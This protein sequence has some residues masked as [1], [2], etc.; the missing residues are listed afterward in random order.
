MKKNKFSKALKHLKSKKLD[1]KIKKLDEAA[2]TN[3]MSG[4]YQQSPRS[5]VGFRLGPPDPA[6]TFVAAADGSWPPGIPGTAGEPYYVRPPD[7]WSGTVDWETITTPEF[8]FDSA[9]GN[10]TDGLID[11]VTNVVK[12]QLPPG[13][14]GF[15]LGPL[16][17]GFVPNHVNDAFTRIG[18]IEKDTRQFVLLGIIQG[19]WISGLNERV[20]S[21]GGGAYPVWDGSSGKFTASNPSFT[22]DMA[23]WFRNEMLKNRFVKNVSYN[24]VGGIPQTGNP[25]PN[26]PQP[27]GGNGVGGG[28]GAAGSNPDG[29]GTGHGSGGNPDVGTPQGD[30]DPG[31]DPGENDLWGMSGRRKRKNRRGSGAR[32]NRGRKKPDPTPSPTPDPQGGRGGGTGNPTNRRGSGARGNRGRGSEPTPSPK[33]DGPYTPRPQGG[34]GGGQGNPTNPRGSGAKPRPE[35]TPSPKPTGP[36]TP[37]PQGG[38][39]G[40]QGNPTNPRG[41]GATPRPTPTPTPRP[42][43]RPTPTPKPTPKSNTQKAYERNRYNNRPEVKAGLTVK[44]AITKLGNF[45][46]DP[47]GA[48]ADFFGDN[49]TPPAAEYATNIAKSVLFNKPITV[50]QEDIPEKDIDKLIDGFNDNAVWIPISVSTDG[51][52]TPYADDNFYFDDKGNVKSNIGPN[53]EKAYYKKNNTGPVDADVG[54]AGYDNPLAAAGQAQVQ[55]VT[56]GDGKPYI[57]YTDH[58]YHNLTS[59]DPGE[60]PDP[61]KTAL[62][63]ALHALTGKADPTKPNTGGMSGYPSNVKGDVKTEVKIDLDDPRVSDAFRE[64]VKREIKYN[65]SGVNTKNESFKSKGRF[66]KEDKKRILR[67]IKQPLR[68]IKQLPKTEKLKGY[69]PNFKGKY[70]PQNTPDVTASK[71]SDQ[72]VMAKNAEGQAWSVGDKYLKGWETTGRMNHVYAR[73]GESDKFFEQ[74][75]ANNSTDVE[76]K[77]QE[78]LNHVYHNKAMLKIDSNYKSPFTGDNIDEQETFDNKIND[79]LFTKVAKRLKKEIDYEKKPAKAGYPNEAPPKIDPNTGYHPKYGK[80]YKYDKLDPI[81]AKTMAGAPTGDPEIDANVKKAS[82]IKEN[83][84][85]DLKNLWLG[86]E[87]KDWKKKL[88]EGMTTQMLTGI[89]PSTGDADLETVSL[90]VSGGHAPVNYGTNLA[91]SEE[92]PNTIPAGTEYTALTNLEPM[93]SVVKGNENDW[94]ATPQEAEYYWLVRTFDQATQT[95]DTHTNGGDN[96]RYSYLVPGFKNHTMRNVHLSGAHRNRP[97]DDPTPGGYHPTSTFGSNDEVGQPYTTSSN[98]GSG[99]GVVLNFSGVGSPRF[100]ALRPVDATQVDTI[101]VHGLIAD[102]NL[103][104]AGAHSS[105]EYRPQLYYWAGNHPDFKKSFLNGSLAKMSNGQNMTQDGWRP[106]NMKPNGDIDPSVDPFLIKYREDEDASGNKNRAPGYVPQR[107]DPVTDSILPPIYSAGHLRVYPYSLKLPEWTQ[108]KDARFMIFQRFTGSISGTTFHV[109][110]VRYQRKSNMKIPALTKPLTD[111]ETSP[112]VRVGAGKESL[113]AKERKKKVKNIIDGGLKYTETKFSK[114]F[115]VRTTLESKLFEKLKNRK[116]IKEGMTTQVLTG[117]LPSTGEADLVN[118]QTGLTG[119]GGVDYGESGVNDSTMTGDGEYT[120]LTVMGDITTVEDPTG[121][122]PWFRHRDFD[123]GDN[124]S[125]QSMHGGTYA[126]SSDIGKGSLE[127][128]IPGYVPA[129]FRGVRLTGSFSGSNYQNLFGFTDDRLGLPNG[130]YNN[131]DGV[132]RKGYGTAL[133]FSDS[134]WMATKDIDTTEVDTLKIHARVSD[135][136]IP[137]EDNQTEVYYWAGNKPGFKSVSGDTITGSDGIGV[138]KPNDGWRPLNQKP[139][140][141][142]DN[143]V[144]TVL[145][146]PVRASNTNNVLQAHT[147]KLPDWATGPKSRYIIFSKGTLSNGTFSM[148]SIRFQRKDAKRVRTLMKPLSDVESSPFVRVGPTKKNEGGKERKKKV[149]DIIRSGLKYTGKKFSKDFPV[150]TDLE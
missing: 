42:P 89:L 97:V 64:R 23:L 47:L 108:T 80:R 119:D 51:T 98:T 90:G 92:D 17:D 56:G 35:P 104:R 32:G 94:N 76:R 106:I 117:I 131:I 99:A 69:R 142:F 143:T 137:N 86:S 78:H 7:H 120:G 28:S 66:L 21:F 43:S 74:I 123:F 81:S 139:D 67:E 127:R 75:T 68:E 31:K 93:T 150:R 138:S 34:R 10:N 5:G 91:N 70:S 25:D 24:A 135:N 126:S 22:L 125:K 107:Y 15:I 39:G 111:I 148:T 100:A 49:V 18:Y 85:S 144:S 48:V 146:G 2:P 46:V 14:R 101:K 72:L 130:Q 103:P 141:S 63:G 8:G 59:D 114:D 3:N 40:G 9:Q 140:G 45:A 149:Q 145:I 95:W 12:T 128:E 83:W 1:E 50:K 20:S 26:A 88:E 55:V 73:V 41:T 129:S 61:I 82:K 147:I 44:D 71:R 121:V 54:V 136:K 118:L 112:F 52:Q 124:P 19:E 57:L 13:S 53:G 77:M 16:V 30:P 65:Q 110:G 38:R 115:P 96:G 62:S 109:S 4:I 58:A 79:P 84:R 133:E 33:P 132:T 27:L 60:V 122:G 11:P 36:Y 102:T 37:R 29:T 105:V 87:R 134:A 113:G 116:I 6:R